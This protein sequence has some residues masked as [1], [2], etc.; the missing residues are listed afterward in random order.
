MFQKIVRY[1]VIFLGLA[2]LC[3][4]TSRQFMEWVSQARDNF[5]PWGT[6][7]YSNGDLVSMSYLDFMDK[8]RMV[9]DF[10][11]KKPPSDCAGKVN[12]Y[13]SGDSYCRR[14]RDTSFACIN[15]YHFH[16]RFDFEL[17]YHLNLSQ[18]NILI[19][20][21]SERYF[22]S[23]FHDLRMFKEFYYADKLSS[24]EQKSNALP[25]SLQATVMSPLVTPHQPTLSAL[26]PLDAANATNDFWKTFSLDAL[27]NKNINQNLQYNMFN[28]NC[29][30]PMFASKALL[31]FYVFNRASG[32]VVISKNKQYLFLKETVMPTGKGSSF[33]PLPKEELDTLVNN[34]NAVYDHYRKEGFNEV[35]LSVIPNAVTVEQPE[36]YN[37]LI[38]DFE[39]DMRLRMKLI[40]VYN[41]FTTHTDTVWY[42]A[43]DTHWNKTGTQRWLDLVNGI[44]KQ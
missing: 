13:L 21:I 34:I 26:L 36:G 22:R 14:L 38:P 28:Y 3:C 23:Y 9:R 2:L 6:Y 11:T 20:E 31:N 41:I 19:I 29:I 35:Y 17:K 42:N 33:S 8:F 7:Q 32:D 5:G 24:V 10:S 37:Q 27:F 4:S 1:I 44:L 40:D 16:K 30:F 15:E 12:L 18:K 39:K 43:G 25:P